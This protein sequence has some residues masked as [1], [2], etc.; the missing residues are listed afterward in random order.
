MWNAIAITFIRR[1]CWFGWKQPFVVGV[2]VSP[3]ESLYSRLSV[4]YVSAC[5][6]PCRFW[7]LCNEKCRG[8]YKYCLATYRRLGSHGVSVSPLESLYSR[9]SVVYVSACL[10]PSVLL[11]SLYSR[12]SV[13]YVSA[14]LVLCRFWSVC[15]EK[16]RE[17]LFRYLP[18]ALL[19]W[20]EAAICCRRASVSRL[21]CWVTLLASIC[22]C[23]ACAVF[24]MTVKCQKPLT[25]SINTFTPVCPVSFPASS[26]PPFP[27]FSCL[28]LSLPP[29]C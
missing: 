1:L 19:V 28:S 24:V 20:L 5:L 23:R 17:I 14:C 3:L 4:V 2:S 13:V 12:L 9:L 16:C 8:E 21:S 26:K 29:S 22:A 27:I 10:V 25:S 15:N 6:V 7:S 18:E 11:E